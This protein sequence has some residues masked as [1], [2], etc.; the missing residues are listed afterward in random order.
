MTPGAEPQRGGGVG[1]WGNSGREG[2]CGGEIRGSKRGGGRGQA[3]AGRHC[4]M[5]QMGSA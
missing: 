4:N 5:K 1:F 2:L 3:G